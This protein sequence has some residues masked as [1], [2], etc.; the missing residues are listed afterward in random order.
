VLKFKNKFGRLRVKFLYSTAI[1]W[2]RYRSSHL[3]FFLT[4]LPCTVIK[5]FIFKLPSDSVL[6]V[7]VYGLMD[8]A[9]AS[10]VIHILELYIFYNLTGE[11]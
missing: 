7:A 5:E 9:V 6:L 4:D 11:Y 2:Y 3:I 1:I 8:T 10:S